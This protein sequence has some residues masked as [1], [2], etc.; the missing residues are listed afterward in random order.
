MVKVVDT[1][2][3][4][5]GAKRFRVANISIFVVL[6]GGQPQAMLCGPAEKANMALRSMSRN[7]TYI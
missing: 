3:G 7:V 4:V 2:F 6:T 5:K 1:Q